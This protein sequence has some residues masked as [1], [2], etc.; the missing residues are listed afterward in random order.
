M[1][2]KEAVPVAVEMRNVLS[3]YGNMS[4][5]QIRRDTSALD[6]SEIC[7]RIEPKMPARSCFMVL[8]NQ[9]GYGWN[10]NAYSAQWNLSST[11]WFYHDSVIRASLSILSHSDQGGNKGFENELEKFN[12]D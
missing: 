4:V 3:K 12:S 2:V 1:N 11:N 5:C 7:F 10:V 6:R 9:F 8:I